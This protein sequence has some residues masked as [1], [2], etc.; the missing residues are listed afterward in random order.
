MCGH[1]A[2]FLIHPELTINNKE[3]KNPQY[4]RN[5]K[6]LST[7]KFKDD[8]KKMKSDRK[9]KNKKMQYGRTFRKLITSYKY[10]T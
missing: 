10:T 7:T 4:K 3:K 1:L 2:Q 6:K 5:Y 9:F 8:F